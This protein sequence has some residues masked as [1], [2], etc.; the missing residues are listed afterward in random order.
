MEKLNFISLSQPKLNFILLYRE[1]AVGQL[2]HMHTLPSKQRAVMIVAQGA[3]L[4]TT[5]C[6]INRVCVSEIL[7]T[8][9][10]K[11]LQLNY[12]VLGSHLWLSQSYLLQKR[13]PHRHALRLLILAA[14]NLGNLPPFGKSN[15]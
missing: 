8:D 9:V 13:I 10:A 5:L 6:T 1:S 12:N 2:L 7:L 11:H 3:N 14:F 15:L 4:H